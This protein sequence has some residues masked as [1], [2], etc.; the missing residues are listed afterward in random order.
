MRLELGRQLRAIHAHDQALTELRSL[1]ERS[2][3]MP[4]A[5]REL[6]GALRSLGAAEEGLVAGQPLLVL[7]AATAEELL[8]LKAR[9]ARPAM[10]PPGLLGDAGFREVQ[11]A[12][13]FDTAAAELVA[14]LG[15]TLA[16]MY[17]SDPARYGVT[18]RDR[19]PPRS[20]D[21][22]RTAAERVAL[23]LGVPELELYMHDQPARDVGLELGSVPTLFV[24][25]WAEEVPRPALV[26]LLARPLAAF[27]RQVPA[28]YRIHPQSLAVYLAA[29]GRLV[30]PGFASGLVSESDLEAR[31]RELS[32]AM[33][34]RSRKPVETAAGRYVAAGG[35]NIE[36]W[37]RAVH[38]SLARAALL[39]A[40][41]VVAVVEMV[42]RT[43]GE[44]LD[45]EGTATDLVRFWVS[46]A[47]VRFRRAVAS[48]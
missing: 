26:Y 13:A 37:L 30:S 4:D 19:L 48:S 25:R 8:T 38:L 39:L 46:D 29:A 5:W 16:R 28:V 45:A 20:G 9:S 14:A 1:L 11:V 41:D 44:T 43:S 27:A 42:Q 40:D 12:A 18:K 34:R 3:K 10:A 23:V 22:V 31:G 47:A 15:E 7:G 2:V 6:A 33:P 21:P 17:P 32:K 35:T 24:P 36:E